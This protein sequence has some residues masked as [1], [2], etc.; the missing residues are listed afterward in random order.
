[1]WALASRLCCLHTGTE[2]T[3]R[4]RCGAHFK[5]RA[6]VVAD[7]VEVSRFCCLLTNSL[8]VILRTSHGHKEIDGVVKQEGGE[9]YETVFF[10]ARLVEHQSQKY[11]I[12]TEKEGFP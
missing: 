8:E 6:E 4:P 7:V 2:E 12:K 1:M 5:V 3:F 10:E 11:G 9:H